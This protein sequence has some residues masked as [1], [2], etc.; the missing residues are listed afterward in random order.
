MPNF[1]LSLLQIGL[2]LLGKIFCAAMIDIAADYLCALGYFYMIHT[3]LIA[4]T[5]IFPS[6]IY[7]IADYFITIRMPCR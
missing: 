2:L 3:N 5:A 7:A 1:C 4:C 6:P